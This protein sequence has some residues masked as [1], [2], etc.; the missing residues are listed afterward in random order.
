[1]GVVQNI[2]NE[3]GAVVIFDIVLGEELA[4][5]LMEV[6]VQELTKELGGVSFFKRMVRGF[7]FKLAD[8]LAPGR[9]RQKQVGDFGMKYVH[10]TGSDL[11]EGGVVKASKL[12]HFLHDDCI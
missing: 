4:A 9:I 8:H 7:Y 5:S 11:T 10:V 6:F 2:E 1:M 12:V 3:V